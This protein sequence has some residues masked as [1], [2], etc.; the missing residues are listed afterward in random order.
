PVVEDQ[1]EPANAGDISAVSQQVVATK[2][3][4]EDAVENVDNDNSI[5]AE[6]ANAEA[7]EEL[8]A[9]EPCVVSTEPD[10][11]VDQSQAEP[12]EPIEEGTSEADVIVPEVIEKESGHAVLEEIAEVPQAVD[13]SVIDSVC[14]EKVEALPAEVAAEGSQEVVNTDSHSEMIVEGGDESEFVSTESTGTP[15]ES[16]V[17]IDSSEEVEVL[18]NDCEEALAQDIDVEAT[19]ESVSTVPDAVSADADV[20]AEQPQVAS[21]ELAAEEYSEAEVIVP[22]PTEE[23]SEVPHSVDDSISQTV[24]VDK[25]ENSTPEAASEVVEE[26]NTTE[27][28]SNDVVL[29]EV[30]RESADPESTETPVESVEVS[31]E[32]PAKIDT[33]VDNVEDNIESVPS[34]V[35]KVDVSAVPETVTIKENVPVE[36]PQDEPIETSTTVTVETEVVAEPVDVETK[37]E[38]V[39]DDIDVP[40]LVEDVVPQ[41]VN[42][43]QMEPATVEE[44]STVSQVVVTP[45]TPSEEKIENGSDGNSIVIESA[46]GTTESLELPNEYPASVDVPAAENSIGK[47]EVECATAEAEEVPTTAEPQVVAVESEVAAKQCEVEQVELIKKRTSEADFIVS[48]AIR[49]EPVPVVSEEVL[50]GPQPVEASVIPTVDDYQTEALSAD[51]AAEVSGEV[52]ISDTSLEKVVGDI[53]N[54]QPTTSE[55]TQVTTESSELFEETSASVEAVRDDGTAAETIADG[56]AVFHMP[57]TAIEQPQVQHEEIAT[58]EI[59]KTEHSEFD[60]TV[61]VIEESRMA[62]VTI[63]QSVEVN[64][65]V[66]GTPEAVPEIR[67]EVN[68]TVT[69][70]NEVVLEGVEGECLATESAETSSEPTKVFEETPATID[71]AVE[72]NPNTEDIGEAIPN[73]DTEVVVAAAPETITIEED[74]AAENPQDEPTDN[75][76][77][78]AAESEVVAEPAEVVIEPLTV[79]DVDNVLQSVE[80][81]VPQTV[82]E[83]QVKPTIVDEVSTVSQEVV[84]PNTSEEMVEGGDDANSIAVESTEVIV[85]APG[86][87]CA[88]VDVPAMENST[89]DVEPESVTAEATEGPAAA[90]PDVAVDQSQVEPAET[91]EKGTSEAD[92]VVSELVEKE[93]SS[94][95]VEEIDVMSQPADESVV[96]MEE[97]S[98]AKST[99]EVLV[100]GTPGNPVECEGNTGFVATNSTDVPKEAIDTSEEPPVTIES[101]EK[102]EVADNPVRRDAVGEVISNDATEESVASVVDAP[103]EQPQLEL[104]ELTA[105]GNSEDEVV[106]PNSK[107][108][109][110]PQTDEVSSSQSV[111]VPEVE[112]STT[113]VVPEVLEEVKI[114]ETHSDDVVVEGVGKELASDKCTEIPVESTEISDESPTAIDTAVEDTPNTEDIGDAITSQDTEVTVAVV[115]EITIV[116]DVVT[117]NP[118][119]EPTDNTVITAA[120]SEVVAEL[121]EV[122]AEPL[123]VNDVDDEPQSVED[124]AVQIIIEV[125]PVTKILE[126]VSVV[127]QETVITETPLEEVVEDEDDA[128]SIVAEAT[129]LPV[130]APELPKETPVTASAMVDL[131]TME[132]SMGKTEAESADI[133]ATQVSASAEEQEATAESDVDVQQSLVEPVELIAERTSEAEVVVS[134]IFKE[135]VSPVVVGEVPEVPQPVEESIIRTVTNGN[136]EVSSAEIAAEASEEVENVKAT[137]E[138]N[139]GVDI[140]NPSAASEPA[141][142]VTESSGLSEETSANIEADRDDGATPETVVEDVLTKGDRKADSGVLD[143]A[144]ADVAVEQ[145]QLEQDEIPGEGVLKSETVATDPSEEVP[146]E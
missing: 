57:D 70:S 119:N 107:I 83:V 22:E 142:L 146:E 61:E 1:V 114:T 23:V 8:A 15:K 144:Q 16:P 7:N 56:E 13:E 18:G 40:K 38:T 127:S 100:T 46:E 128:K 52:T 92:V 28:H 123:T 126:E 60:P 34:Q 47:T 54:T 10:V 51:V 12:S 94:A 87:A 122:V 103:E 48:E 71:T 89:D 110:E 101:T 3:S 55:S 64:D 14:D 130:G 21:V 30:E 124:A 85:E 9:V 136:V 116:E 39:K 27:N 138:M 53:I 32:S 117:E 143:T 42:E 97:V 125:Q 26:V 91:I 35:A 62:E 19:E 25:V 96:C 95:I 140:S 65:V 5:V 36:T 115:P 43:V 135:E 49:N 120:K 31:E 41:T 86:N 72:D 69:H 133:E 78:T 139:V 81:V 33:A 44:V 73:Q 63:S 132:N 99:E 77:A 134:E 129:E 29:Q 67:E 104:E 24:E 66:I 137:S 90:L 102:V 68:T 141:E 50:E 37:S 84:I 93:S 20:P 109:E 6:S 111:E 80:D 58:Q 79:N 82:D 131:R 2:T 75:T 45:D 145:P 108:S 105:E 17:S 88:T 98:G 106:V 4:S 121:I 76:V 113:E 118:Q 11:A 59:L 74:V 112:I